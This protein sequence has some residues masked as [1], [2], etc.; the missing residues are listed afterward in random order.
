M[1][2]SNDRYWSHEIKLDDDLT[3]YVHCKW[4]DSEPDHIASS[5]VVVVKDR[6][7]SEEEIG[8]IQGPISRDAANERGEEIANNWYD[9]QNG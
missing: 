3:A 1:V 5:A 2:N 9:R 6:S 7:G 8:T 4:I